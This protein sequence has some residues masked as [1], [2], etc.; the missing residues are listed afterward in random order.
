MGLTRPSGSSNTAV[1]A[2]SMGRRTQSGSSSAAGSLPRKA[3]TGASLPMTSRSGLHGAVVD[4]STSAAAQSPN[5]ITSRSGSHGAA[6]NADA[7]AAGR[8]SKRSPSRSGSHGASSAAVHSS[9]S[10][11]S[12]RSRITNPWNLFQ[13][14]NRN[15]GL[16]SKQLAVIYKDHK[17]SQP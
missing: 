17:A 9:P 12:L 1:S 10:N 5:S 3:S 4:E 2:S 14:D 8:P 7:M 6:L 13:Y 11:R 15:R 16:N